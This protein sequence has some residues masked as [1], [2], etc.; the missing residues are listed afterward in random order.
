MTDGEMFCRPARK[1]MTL[2][3]TDDQIVTMQT[4]SSARCGSPQPV[5]RRDAEDLRDDGR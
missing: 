2:R 5:R 1:M 4:A 3:P